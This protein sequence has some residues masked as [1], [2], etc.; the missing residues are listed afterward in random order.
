MSNL[1][2]QLTNIAETQFYIFLWRKYNLQ[3]NVH[4]N[5]V[6]YEYEKSN[7]QNGLIFS[8]GVYSNME[9]NVK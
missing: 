4:Q 8:A 9:Q 5:I 2:I 3:R 6:Y 7:W 1:F